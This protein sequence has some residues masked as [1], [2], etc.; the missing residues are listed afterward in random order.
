[1]SI[2]G[3]MQDLEKMLNDC[4]DPETGEINP[5]DDEAYQA[6]REELA[7]G[8][9]EKLAKV[10]ANLIATAQG[11]ESEIARMNEQLN[12]LRK[13]QNWIEDYMLRIYQE[14]P[15][16]KNLKIQAGTFTI[17]ARTSMRCI[18]DD[19]D[20]IPPHFMKRKETTSV[21]KERLKKI[22]TTGTAVPGAHLQ[23]VQHLQI[24]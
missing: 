22:L 4:A 14:S 3:D 19:E 12:R 5:A 16:D 10:R 13:R 2:Y 6:L 8:G 24:S 7:V 18:I 1:M 23:T 15:K 20:V 21:D 17:G 11:L 9:L